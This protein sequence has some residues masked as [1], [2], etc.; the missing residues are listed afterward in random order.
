MGFGFRVRVL[1]FRLGPRFRIEGDLEADEGQVRAE[2]SS[3]Q[4]EEGHPQVAEVP[5]GFRV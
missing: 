3:G 5:V 1:F 4:A 2:G